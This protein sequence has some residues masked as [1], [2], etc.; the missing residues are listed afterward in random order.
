MTYTTAT[1]L[2]REYRI[3]LDCTHD[4]PEAELAWVEHVFAC[5]NTRCRSCGRL[6]DVSGSPEV[7]LCGGCLETGAE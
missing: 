2:P 6:V 3:A 4:S 5:A 7:A 1:D